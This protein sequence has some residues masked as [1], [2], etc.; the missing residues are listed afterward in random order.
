MQCIEYYKK[1]NTSV[2]VTC[3]DA[4]KTFDMIDHWLLFNKLLDRNMPLSIIRILVFQP[5]VCLCDGV[6]LYLHNFM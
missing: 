2:F 1:R 4:S 5:K 3:L 6:M